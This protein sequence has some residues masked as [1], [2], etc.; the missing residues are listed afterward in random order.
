[1]LDKGTV[2]VLVGQG[3]MVRD[4]ISLLKMARNLKLKNCLF[5]EFSV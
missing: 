5:I 2:P 4:L 3:V 1:M